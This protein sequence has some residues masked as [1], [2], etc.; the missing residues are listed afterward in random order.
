M[1]PIY[2]AELDQYTKDQSRVKEIS[3]WPYNITHQVKEVETS[4]VNI[5]EG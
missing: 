2:K 3:T 1:N 5:L 4:K